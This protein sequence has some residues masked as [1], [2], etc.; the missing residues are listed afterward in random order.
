MSYTF[1]FSWDTD[2]SKVKFKDYA[3]SDKTITEQVIS[4]NNQV[5]SKITMYRGD[6]DIVKYIK[7]NTMPKETHVV[8][9]Y[10]D[11]SKPESLVL[12]GI[13]EVIVIKATIG[14]SYTF[15]YTPDSGN[16]GFPYAHFNIKLLEYILTDQYY[17][18]LH[19]VSLEKESDNQSKPQQNNSKKKSRS[20]KR[21]SSGS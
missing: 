2:G 6:V 10:K 19:Q 11:L 12:S 20:N 4:S 3:D 8:A 15:K 18:P 1:T 7:K 9:I 17:S 13:R 16:R 5:G 21:K 14:S